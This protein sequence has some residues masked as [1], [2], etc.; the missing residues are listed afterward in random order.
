MHQEKSLI[1]FLEENINYPDFYSEFFGVKE[2]V[3]KG[4]LI[5]AVIFFQG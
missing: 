2:T 1:F 4:C 5:K 3:A